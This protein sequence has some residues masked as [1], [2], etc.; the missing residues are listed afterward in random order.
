MTN[1]YNSMLGANAL[2]NQK[3][4]LSAH[5]PRTSLPEQPL[6]HRH[7]T[8]APDMLSPVAINGN[9]SSSVDGDVDQQRTSTVKLLMDQ[10]AFCLLD[11]GTIQQRLEQLPS[12]LH[13]LIQR[14]ASLPSTQGNAVA[15]DAL[16]SQANSI[17]EA[18]NLL[19]DIR[20]LL[21]VA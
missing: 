14:V 11:L 5:L 7:T 21:R 10:C 20:H 12:H 15:H 1:S 6:A 3:P 16:N 9:N 18:L 8:F 19:R 13:R 4:A 2:S 17:A